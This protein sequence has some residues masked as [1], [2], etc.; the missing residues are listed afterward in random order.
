M[1]IVG[2]LV[3]NI[4]LRRRGGLPPRPGR[5]LPPASSRRGLRL[6]IMFLFN[7]ICV[8]MFLKTTFLG[9]Q[10]SPRGG[11]QKQ[12]NNV[13]GADP[14]PFMIKRRSLRIPWAPIHR[15]RFRIARAH[16]STA[17]QRVKQGGALDLVHLD[18][19]LAPLPLRPCPCALE[20]LPLRPCPCPC[21]LALPPLPS[22]LSL[23]L[24]LHLHLMC[25]LHL[26]SN[27]HVKLR[28]D[29]IAHGDNVATCNALIEKTCC[30]R[31]PGLA[32]S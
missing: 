16:A 4:G 7:N 9:F 3:S 31:A 15:R 18:L 26:H 24:A 28:E 23:L 5:P 29:D 12:Q 11:F 32:Q 22:L 19:A 2:K 6:N 10:I 30:V 17:R 25:C 13:V 27:L 14:G 8:L 1:Q 21:A 20:P